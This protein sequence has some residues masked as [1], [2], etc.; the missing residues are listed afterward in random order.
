LTTADE[1]LTPAERD[2]AALAARLRAAR[3]LRN[4]GHAIVA[5][6]VGDELFDR[7]TADAEALLSEVAAAPDRIRA[8]LD[9]VD[10]V[11]VLPPPDGSGRTKFPDG[12][13]T[14]KA[15]PLGIAADM[16]RDGDVAVLRTTLGPAFEGAPGRAHGGVVAALLDEVMGFV[17]S[18]HATTAYTGRLTVTYR[19][20][21]PLGVELEL[22]A[23]LHSRH[24]RKLRIEGD[25]HHGTTLLAHSEG[26]F[27]AVDPKH[28]A[29]G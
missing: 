9:M 5:H 1:A 8:T 6:D 27:I 14:G 24:G 4:L 15:N 23:K 3:A 20:P 16:T 21:T 28:F 11:F 17:L 19:A 22:R 25:A 10:S 29:S 7:M 18:I 26:L 2:R 12:I 13:V